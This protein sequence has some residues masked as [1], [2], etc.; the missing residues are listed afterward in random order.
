MPNLNF[1]VKNKKHTKLA[2]ETVISR[3]VNGEAG[4]VTALR[5]HIATLWWAGLTYKLSKLK[6]ISE[7]K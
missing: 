6:R 1:F 3:D 2:V 7:D 4:G 5:G